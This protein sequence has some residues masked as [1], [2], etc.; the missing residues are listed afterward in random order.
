LAETDDDEFTH[1]AK[2]VNA[3]SYDD[4]GRAYRFTKSGHPVFMNTRLVQLFTLRFRSMGGWTS[5][6]SKRIG[7]TGTSP[8]EKEQ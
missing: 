1:W 7:L 6:L 3:L 8:L 2:V 5:E 4:M